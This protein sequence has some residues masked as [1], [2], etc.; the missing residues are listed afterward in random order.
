[1]KILRLPLFIC[2]FT[3]LI[4][5]AQTKQITLNEIWDGTFSTKR[6]D[7]LHSMKN[8]QQ[9]SVL[10]FDRNTRSTSIDI[11]DYKTLKK[12]KTLVNS[13]SINEL[14]YF[15]DYTFSQDESKIILATN[16]ESIYRRST[17]G[18]YYVFD[19]N[20][21]SITLI[22]ENRIQEPTFSPD[23]TKVAYGF[24]NNLYIKDL[25]TGGTT[26]ITFDGEKN[27]IIN[28]ITDWVYEE[29]FAFV[30]AFEW[31][32]DSNKI[33]FIRFDETDVPEFSMDIYGTGLYQTQQVF[34][35]P[36]AGEKNA[37]VSLHIYHLDTNKTIPVDVEKAYSDFYIPRIKWTNNPDILSAQYMN[38]HQ[39]ELDLWLI[40]AETNTSNLALAEKDDAYISVTDNL[41]FLEDNSFIWTS[42]KDGYNHI[43]HYSKDGE[44]I[45]QVTK[46]NWEVTNYYGYNEKSNRI[47]YQSVEN[48]S[49]NRDVYSIKLNGRN[50]TR[51]TK[52]E[53][54]NNASFSADFS[55]FINT[56]SSATTPPEY[57]LNSA[58]SGN[59]IK[60]IKD[61][62][63]LSKKLSDYKTSKKEFSTIN[64]NGNDLNMWMIKPADFDASKQYPLLMYQYSGPGSQQVANRWN[65]SNDYW[66]Q[67]LAQ[68]GYIIACVD[69]RGTGFKGAKFKKVT[70]NELGKYEVEDQIEAAKQLGALPYID[71]S[72]IGIW[73]WSYGGFMSSN[74]LFKGNDVFKMA[75]AVAPVTSW[76]FYDTIYTERY[77]TTPQENPSGY[78]DNSPINH[79]NKL[80]GDYLLIHGSA[81]D[82]V[83]LQNTMRLAEALIQADKPFEWAVYPDDNHSIYGGNTRLHLYKKMTTFIN[84]K[85]G[86]KREKS[87][88]NEVKKAEIKG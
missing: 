72:R 48:G 74:A 88:V 53:G 42:E 54:T 30:R 35:Y 5:S 81:D 85:L 46:G 31:N 52:S 37:V 73:G 24:E 43:Y 13:S 4:L 15:T 41:T 51:L 65:N 39:N 70:Q 69:G 8:G 6:M 79:V 26:Q 71:A 60:S 38:R 83:H 78:D 3:T 21:K 18:N 59:L 14:N 87:K 80:K 47:F 57:T 23:G 2:L 34:K 11:Y 12:I 50:K 7:V 22:S 10:N 36:K 44:L 86:D 67:H 33:A 82:N 64:V 63:V 20:D 56:F 58:S 62:D 66:Y 27:K 68:Q 19:T 45:N 9:Y 32:A 40:N 28:G 84:S 77:M 76:R 1:M 17:L 16:E 55:Y 75:I 49:I 29:E 61:N 25:I